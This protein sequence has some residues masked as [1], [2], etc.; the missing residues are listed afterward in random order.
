MSNVLVALE[1]LQI[2]GQMGSMIDFMARVL[3]PYVGGFVAF[4]TG[5]CVDFSSEDRSPFSSRQT[6]HHVAGAV[7]M[8]LELADYP[9]FGM[10]SYAVGFGVD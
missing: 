5:S 8:G 6:G 4:R 2:V 7:E 1:A 10:A 3:R 9:R